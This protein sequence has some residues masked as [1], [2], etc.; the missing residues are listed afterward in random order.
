MELPLASSDSEVFTPTV[1]V[2]EMIR[3][4]PEKSEDG[5]YHHGPLCGCWLCDGDTPEFV[6]E[7]NLV[8][9]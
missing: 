5:I 3:N 6:P 4:F 1:S 9:A 7:K 8:A 2:V